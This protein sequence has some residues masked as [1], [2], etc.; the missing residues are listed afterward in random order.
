MTLKNWIFHKK[1]D[2]FIIIYMDDILMYSKAT[3]EHMGHLE[4]V[5][6][7]LKDN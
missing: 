4:Y 7:K 2:E 3:E 6:K 5:L 1:L